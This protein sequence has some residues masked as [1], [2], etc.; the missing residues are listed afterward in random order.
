MARWRL[1]E[2]HYLKV[3]GTKWE[4]TEI[5]RTTGAP[6]RQQFDVP[7]YIDPRDADDL[8]R[9]G[10]ADPYEGMNADPIVVVIDAETSRKNSRDMLF[11]G[12]P[13]PGML[14][15]DDEAKALTDKFA[16]GVWVP[17]A[18]I[19]PI[20]QNESYANKLISGLLDEMTAQREAAPAKGMT[21]L[22]ETMNAMM[23]VQ[24]ALLER[25]APPAGAVARRL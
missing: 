2:A 17:T 23:K 1:T 9:H 19:D 7:L 22:I 24:S 10:Q 8:K 6:K 11:V 13:T 5:D 4:Y 14:P 18:N 15:M 3:P 20:S 25:M 16:K 21:E 12:S